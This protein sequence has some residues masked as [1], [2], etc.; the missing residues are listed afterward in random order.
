MKIFIVCILLAA[1][2]KA[3]AMNIVNYGTTCPWGWCAS[4][5]NEACAPEVVHNNMETVDKSLNSLAQNQLAQE[6]DFVDLVQ[7]SRQLPEAERMQMYFDTLG[8]KND[9]EF[10]E[11]IGAREVSEQTIDSLASKMHLKKAQA[12]I[13]AESIS[14]SLLGPRK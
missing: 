8:L 13:V 4:S 9:A 7:K 11:F 2:I 14:H 6:K 12:R 10:V 1:S 3:Q 5:P